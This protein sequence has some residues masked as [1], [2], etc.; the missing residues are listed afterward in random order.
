MTAFLQRLLQ[1]WRRRWWQPDPAAVAAF[2]GLEP[3]AVVTGGS[4]GIGFELA[5]RFAAA[6]HDVMLVARRREPLEQ[7]AARIRAE[8]TVDVAIL[9]LDVTTAGAPQAIDAALASYRA[10]ADVLVNNAGIGLSGPFHDHQPEDVQRLLDLNVVAL[11]RLTRH[12]LPGMRARGRGGILNVAS[13]GGYGPGPNQAAYYASKAYVLSLTEAIAAETAGEGVRV[14]ALAPGPVDTQF[15]ARMGAERA[16]Y[17][18]L[19]PPAS[20]QSVARAGYFGFM[21]G[22]RIT[23]PGVLNPFLALA[24]RV[25]PH[26]IVIPIVGWLLKPRRGERTDA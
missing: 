13:L 5:R 7:A 24:M 17:R 20:A 10:Y 3:M 22:L 16:F 11:T 15:H 1:A 23:V 25:M 21:L 18:V 4:E 2:E 14:C 6:G 19:V 12:F 26:R 8:T 9:S